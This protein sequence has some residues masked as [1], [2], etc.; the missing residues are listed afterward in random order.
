MKRGEPIR[1]AV[2]SDTHGLLRPEVEKILEICDVIIHAGDFDNQ[3]LYHKLHI[4]QPL[5]AVRGNNDGFWGMQLPLVRRFELGGVRF[6]MA[7]ERS[8][9][10]HTLGDEQ[11]VIFGHSHMYYQQ[12]EDG[13]L[14]LN[15]GSC[16][17]KR[18]TLPLSLA[19][20]TL[21]DGNYSVKTIWL[22]EEYGREPG[23]GLNLGAEETAE[24]WRKPMPER[25]GG[26]SR[27][28]VTEAERSE[29]RKMKGQKA[30]KQEASEQEATEQRASEREEAKQAAAR[31]RAAEQK[32][33]ERDQ[34]FLIAKIMRFMKR[35]AT[36]N[37]VADNLKSEPAF[38]EMI[39]RICVTHPGADA[40]QILD[41]LEVNRIFSVE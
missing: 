19:V 29:F 4:K 26:A 17:Y 33:Q 30:A 39:Y 20:M 22:D 32:Q 2:I 16:G 8:D 34:L 40:H 41:K 24:G 12:I 14:W 23:A 37:W 5:Y 27:Q 35:G 7:H 18:F 36:V 3:M 13:R 6:I 31:Q 15:P 1:A 9:I 10:P 38:V 11:V 21:Q 25:D 28:T